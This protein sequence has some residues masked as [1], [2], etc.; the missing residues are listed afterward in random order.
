MYYSAIEHLAR[1]VL[2]E[3]WKESLWFMVTTD[4]SLSA[5]FDESRT[6]PSRPFSVVAGYISTVSLWEEFSRQWRQSL[7]AFNLP[8]LHMKEFYPQHGQPQWNTEKRKHMERALLL[9]AEIA[10]GHTLYAVRAVIDNSIFREVFQTFKSPKAR[11]R[12]APLTSPYELGAWACCEAIDNQAM[13]IQL[14]GKPLKVVFDAGNSDHH[15]FKIGYER[16][17]SNK[18]GTQLPRHLIPGDDMEQLPLQAADQYAWEM[19]RYYSR[20]STISTRP[21]LNSLFQKDI[22]RDVLEIQLNLAKI[23]EIMDLMY[24]EKINEDSK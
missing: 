13:R 9:F 24:P 15:Y 14:P 4:N 6:D 2:P 20:E 18:P 5:Y 10:G 8:Y 11:R 22:N 12:L 16:Y 17:R 7:K 21:S 3:Q 23:L 19:S 1:T